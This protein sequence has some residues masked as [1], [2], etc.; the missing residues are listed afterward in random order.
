[1]SSIPAIVRTPPAI[2]R[3]FARYET[4]GHVGGDVVVVVPNPGRPVGR[5]GNVVP[6]YRTTSLAVVATLVGVACLF[7]GVAQLVVA[8]R[9]RSWRWLLIL[10][11][12]LGMAACVAGDRLT[13][14][15][16]V[17]HLP[18]PYLAV[19]AVCSCRRR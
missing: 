18:H 12:V 6:S 16:A 3:A 15:L 11:G 10:T 4:Y 1:M 17:G 19:V 13:D 8:T 2:R 7:G 9:V 14:R 5:I